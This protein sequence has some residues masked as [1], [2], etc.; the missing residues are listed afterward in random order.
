MYSRMTL[1]FWSA[2]YHSY[3]WRIQMCTTTPILCSGRCQAQGFVCV[4]QALCQPN[5]TPSPTQYC[6]HTP[7]LFLGKVTHPHA[8][9]AV[10]IQMAHK[11]LVRGL[12][13]FGSTTH[14][15]IIRHY[16]IHS[17]WIINYSWYYMCIKVRR[18]SRNR[19][20]SGKV[21]DLILGEKLTLS[22]TGNGAGFGLLQS[23][24][25]CDPQS[26]GTFFPLSRFNEVKFPYG[27]QTCVT[28]KPFL[29]GSLISVCRLS[30]YFLERHKDT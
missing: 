3:R 30:W 29:S 11:F 19:F 16:F 14:V 8:S 22:A 6:G 25:R 17:K 18:P 26:R 2:V 13:M 5:C 23:S 9:H 15:N 10:F 21:N 28:D 7:T 27:P 12:Q 24:F 4:I 1:N 20:E